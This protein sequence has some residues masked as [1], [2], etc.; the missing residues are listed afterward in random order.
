MDDIIVID[1]GE[2]LQEVEGETAQQLQYGQCRGDILVRG[3]L[4]SKV[5]KKLALYKML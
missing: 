3:K 1:K 4:Y 2:C 5:L